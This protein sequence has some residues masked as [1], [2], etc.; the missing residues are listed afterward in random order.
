MRDA[1]VRGRRGRQWI[2]A[3][4]FLGASWAGACHSDPEST[5]GVAERFLDAHYVNIDLPAA[6]ALAAGV[7][8]D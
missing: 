1:N 2:A 5:R 3:L 7:A 8:K 4:L 6:E